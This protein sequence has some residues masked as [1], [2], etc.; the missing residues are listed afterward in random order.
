MLSVRVC[1][2]R[3]SR[4]PTYVEALRLLRIATT[5]EVLYY[6]TVVFWEGHM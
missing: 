4:A 3:R 5:S 6:S 1:W 2:L